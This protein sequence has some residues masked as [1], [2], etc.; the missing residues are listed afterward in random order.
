MRSFVK[1][2]LALLAICLVVPGVVCATG[3]GG[4]GGGAA[5]DGR[6][7]TLGPKATSSTSTIALLSPDG[8]HIGDFVLDSSDG[9]F[10]QIFAVNG[11]TNEIA[12]GT[13]PNNPQAVM[14]LRDHQGSLIAYDVDGVPTGFTINSLSH[15]IVG[16]G[17]ILSDSSITVGSG[18]SGAGALSWTSGPQLYVIDFGAF[19]AGVCQT[20]AQTM[21]GL[22]NGDGCTVGTSVDASTYFGSLFVNVTSAGNFK[23]M[24]CPISS[25]STVNPASMTFTIQL[26]RA[27]ATSCEGGN[28]R[29][30]AWREMPGG[31]VVGRGAASSIPA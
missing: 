3:Y 15:T 10:V 9:A 1:N 23:L 7:D 26:A 14:D 18:L 5:F 8:T 17:P 27:Y 24:A 11:A 21:T 20:S 28:R 29:R 31:R 16:A 25:S 2:I 4:G 30:H 19:S 13:G 12:F 6:T 22:L